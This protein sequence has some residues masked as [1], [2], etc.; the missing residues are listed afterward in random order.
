MKTSNK[1]LIGLVLLLFSFPLILM[2]GFKAAIK[3]DRYVVRS[4]TGYKVSEPEPLKAFTAI[5]LN[6]IPF[7]N[8]FGLKARIKYGDKFSYR[9]KNYDE[10]NPEQGRTDN[11]RVSWAGDTLVVDYN[12]KAV[13]KANEPSFFYGIEMDITLPRA[14]PVIA[15]G[16]T[17]TIDSSAVALGAMSFQLSNEAQLGVDGVVTTPREGTGVD[18]HKES[19]VY[20]TVFPDIAI[21]AN[22]ASVRIGDHVHIKNLKL[23]LNGKSTINF[24]EAVAIDTL[25]GHISEAS[26]FNAPYRFS[27]FL[28]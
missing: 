8:E 17:V 15:G 3:N 23:D 5:K 12:L 28:K 18:L 14:V 9:I 27:K 13:V 11:C 16:T 20:Q 21:N 6:G 19:V 4:N 26:F 25:S 1:L 10:A 7:N 2:M 22:N 24:S